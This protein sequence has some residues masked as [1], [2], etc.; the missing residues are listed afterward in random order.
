[1][2]GLMF[3]F[4]FS[5]CIHSVL[6]SQNLVPNPGFE[7]LRNKRPSMFPW[8]MVNTIDYFVYHESMEGKIFRTKIKDKNFKLRKPRSGVAYVGLRVWPRY[9]EFLIV[10]LPQPLEAGKQ[11]YFE[12]FLAFSPHANAYLRSIGVSF[13]SFKPPYA[14]K[15]IVAEFPPQLEIFNYYGIID[16]TDWFKVAGVF[17]ANGEERFMTIG[18]FS[19]NNSD[20]FKRKKFSLRKREAYYYIDD[21]ALY[22]LDNF[23]YPLTREE[24]QQTAKSAKIQPKLILDNPDLPEVDEYYKIIHFPQ[25]STELTYEAYQKLGFIIEYLN[26]HPSASL[27]VVGYADFLDNRDKEEQLKIAARRASNILMFISGNRIQKSRI[28]AA[29]MPPETSADQNESIKSSEK[30]HYAEIL[31]PNDS[32]D[33]KKIRT[34]RFRVI[35]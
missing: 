7:D 30:R 33:Q 4:L 17:T 28:T 29:Y 15:N 16:T 20:K 1:M 9:S 21:I 5:F 35:D 22:K 23:G 3:V 10:E 12:M 34:S 14:Q 25:G 32:E 27:Y 24:D 26:K 13:Y 18:N 19:K 11:Y 6:Y 8:Q 31:F 2:R